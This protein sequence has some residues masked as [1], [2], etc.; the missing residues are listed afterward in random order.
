MLML[1]EL[2]LEQN[3]VDFVLTTGNCS[4]MLIS[5]HNCVTLISCYHSPAVDKHLHNETKE[6][7]V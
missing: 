7:C 3:K 2:A 5:G 6:K 1:G 4:K